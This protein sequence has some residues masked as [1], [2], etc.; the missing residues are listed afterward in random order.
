MSAILKSATSLSEDALSAFML[1]VLMPLETHTTK[2]KTEEH[3]LVLQEFADNPST[4]SRLAGQIREFISICKNIFYD[5]IQYPLF[6]SALERLNVLAALSTIKRENIEKERRFK[7]EEQ[8]EQERRKRQ[9]Q[10]KPT[11]QPEPIPQPKPQ[12][13][14]IP[15]PSQK[16]KIPSIVAA[17]AIVAVVTTASFFGLRNN[18]KPDILPV[19]PVNP[20]KTQAVPTVNTEKSTSKKQTN[21]P[22]KS[23]KQTSDQSQQTAHTLP[24]T[25][26]PKL[27]TNEPAPATQPQPAP[28][29]PMTDKELVEAGTK[30]YRSFEFEKALELFEKAANNGQMLAQ[31]NLA[32]MYLDGNGARK[33]MPKAAQWFLKAAQQGDAASQYMIGKMYLNGQGVNENGQQAHTWLKKAADQGNEDAIRLLKKL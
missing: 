21:K 29:K 7:E 8:K 9:Q 28:A 24:V 22:A 20:I 30:A 19:T 13:G 16:S 31:Y 33:N 3:I 17:F 26:K 6:R 10:P 18:N 23:P 5:R 4:D 25:A 32:K 11:P 15:T 2:M 14:P 12:P 27:Q 1:L